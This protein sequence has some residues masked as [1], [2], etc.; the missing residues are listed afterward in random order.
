MLFQ[1]EKESLLSFMNLD[2]LFESLSKSKFR[3]SF[4]LKGKDVE[5]IK[6]KGLETIESH[7][8]DFVRKRLGSMVIANDGAQTPMK[9]HPVF[10]AQH[11]TGTCCRECLYKWHKIEKN[12]CLTE[13]EI[14]YIVLIIMMWI[15]REIK[16]LT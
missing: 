4:H 10:I 3:S 15:K 14:E 11:A 12:K 7:A 13:K 16:N 6:N 1:R 2:N 8:C 5:Y 9:G